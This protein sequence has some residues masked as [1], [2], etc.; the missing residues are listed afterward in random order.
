[1]QNQWI[2]FKKWGK[3]EQKKVLRHAWEQ[4]L[5]VLTATSIA[6]LSRFDS[7]SILFYSRFLRSQIR[8]TRAFNTE[9]FGTLTT[10]PMLLH[11]NILCTDRRKKELSKNLA[12]HVIW[13]WGLNKLIKIWLKW[14]IF[15]C[16]WFKAEPLIYS[17]KLNEYRII[18]LSQL[19]QHLHEI[20][21]C[22]LFKVEF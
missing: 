9:I 8:L 12:M 14:L 15:C 6:F 2:S 20:F 19:K 5:E 10:L 21:G 13:L 7:F 1:M 3:E 16:G 4:G 22:S 18:S 11:W 17:T